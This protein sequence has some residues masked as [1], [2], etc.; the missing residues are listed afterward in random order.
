ML[1]V[2]SA[3]LPEVKILQ[4]ISRKDN[5]GEKLYTFS[6]REMEKAGIRFRSVEE[7]VYKIAKRNTLYGIHFQNHPKP[8]AKLVFCLKGRGNDFVVDLR[9]DSPS[10]KKWT[11]IP[12]DSLSGRQVLVPAGFGHAFLSG[13]DDTRLVFRIDEYFDVNLSRTVSYRDEDLNIRFNIRNPILSDYDRD[14]PFL[15][16]SDCN[17]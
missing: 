14:A 9:K 2:E 5:R 6:E 16:D 4:W 13:E 1:R 17:L 11:L 7:A 3:E 15:K 10:Y 8:Q 12:L